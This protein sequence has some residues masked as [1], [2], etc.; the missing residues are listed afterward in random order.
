MWIQV[1]LV[2]MEMASIAMDVITIVLHQLKLAVTRPAI[3]EIKNSSTYAAVGFLINRGN[4]SA[5]TANLK[6][7]LQD[8]S[9]LKCNWIK[10]KNHIIL[11]TIIER[12][13]RYF[14]SS[15]S[16]LSS[17]RSELITRDTFG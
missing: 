16:F 6:L 15:S 12:C 4:A 11:K 10:T 3:Q 13:W 7:A 2:T 8:S 14:F 9:R 5:L 17:Y 1:K